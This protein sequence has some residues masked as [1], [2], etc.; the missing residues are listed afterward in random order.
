MTRKLTRAQKTFIAHH[1]GD[2][3]TTDRASSKPVLKSL[4]GYGLVDTAYSRVGSPVYVLTEEAYDLAGIAGLDKV[5]GLAQ[6]YKK[7]A[8][9][10]DKSIIIRR[11]GV[12]GHTQSDNAYVY[13]ESWTLVQYPGM[14]WE[15]EEYIEQ[16]QRLWATAIKNELRW[17]SH[18][19]QFCR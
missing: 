16:S 1:A 18:T 6:A 15:Q 5:A 3:F 9:I 10:A 8:Q 14:L 19:A 11:Y 13:S 12:Q 17:K 4:R 2:A 7:A